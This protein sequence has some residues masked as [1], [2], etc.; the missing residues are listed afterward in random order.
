VTTL[1]AFQPSP[2]QPFQFQA[3]LDGNPYNVIVTWNIF[4]QR[5]YV[6]VYDPSMNLIVAE[7]MTGSPLGY[8]IDLVW[9][10][11]TTSTLVW[12]PSTGN[13]EVNP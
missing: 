13:F 9:S 12:R 4:G 11:F 2:S 1:V 3:T 7:A 6:N 10:Y 8:D 5:Y